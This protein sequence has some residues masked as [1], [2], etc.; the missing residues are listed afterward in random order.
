MALNGEEITDLD[1]DIGYH[2]RGVEK[3]GERQTWH[4]FIPYCARVDYL[5]GAANDLPYV[6]AVETLADIKVPERAQSIRV[7]LSEL[8]RLSNHLVWFATYAHDVGAMTPN[9]Y[10]FAEREMILDIVELIT[11]GRLHPSWF[12]LGGVAADLPDG[13]RE[14]VD[15]FVEIF[16]GRLKEYENLIRKNPI[17]KARTQGIGRISLKTPWTGALRGRICGRAG[18][19]G[20]C[21]RSRLI[22]AMRTS[23]LMFRRQR[24]VIVMRATS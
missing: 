18:W 20:I 7:L 5:A 15:A 16:P 8:F 10:A 6:L 4:Q 12:R 13:W 19:N 2:H 17:F 3:I 23:S 24:E 11:G 1:L 22:P 21:E 9:F 14:A